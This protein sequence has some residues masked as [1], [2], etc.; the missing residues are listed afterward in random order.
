M[1]RLVPAA[2]VILA[3]LATATAAQAR[4]TVPRGWLGVVAD[5]TVA[6]RPA[7]FPSEFGKM[8]AAGAESVRLIFYWNEAQPQRNGPIDFSRTDAQ[9]GAAARAHM[10]MLVT[11]M[12]APKWAAANSPTVD[13]PVLVPRRPATFARYLRALVRR[14]GSH[15]SFWRTHRSIP[16]APVR[17][18]QVWNEPALRYDW[19]LPRAHAGQGQRCGRQ[20]WVKTYVPLLRASARA[21]RGADRR[22]KVVLAGNPNYAWAY[23]C[24][25]Y[26]RHAGHLFDQVAIHPY[27][28]YVREHCFRS[29]GERKCFF[30]LVDF[31]ARVRR[32]MRAHGDARKPL[33]LSE[34]SWPAAKG[35]TY[36]SGVNVTPAGQ[37]SR[38]REALPALA[39]LRRRDHIAGIWWYTWLSDYDPAFDQP[40]RFSGLRK[41]NANGTIVNRPG[42]AA[43]RSTARR[44]EGR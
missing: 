20:P 29:H 35:R 37:A 17:L 42:L 11:V 32:V 14:Y 44:L 28:Y 5:S 41:L 19:N 1:R 18:W 22:A 9:V 13:A 33:L 38:I 30:G 15:G 43:F 8:K 2:L 27:T 34:L 21:I 7:I 16:K 40:F 24:A 6:T 12:W 10:R 39:K 31:I 26:R 25:L 4:R 23:M 36:D 3:L